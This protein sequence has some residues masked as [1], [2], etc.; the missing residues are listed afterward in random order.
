MRRG[1][2]PVGAHRLNIYPDGNNNP[3]KRWWISFN[4]AN[5]GCRMDKGTL[6]HMWQVEIR[7]N[8]TENVIRKRFRLFRNC[9]F[10]DFV[11][12]TSENYDK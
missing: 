1:E 4:R 6:V 3:Y 9:F 7:I 5:E 12:E 8:K 2:P 11:T 10:Y